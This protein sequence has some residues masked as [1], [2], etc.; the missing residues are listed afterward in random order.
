MKKN[1]DITGMSCGGCVNSV[2]RALMQNP[3]II[4][5][6]VQLNTHSA[7]VT[8]SKP[9]SVDELQ[10]QLSDIGNYTIEEAI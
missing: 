5:A 6:D 10:S 4:D 9:V 3:D 7:V 2:K 1:Y 8:R